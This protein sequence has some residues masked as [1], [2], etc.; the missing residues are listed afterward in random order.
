M[1]EYQIRKATVA[2]EDFVFENI[3]KPHLREPE[4]YEISFSSKLDVYPYLV[5][6]DGIPISVT[7][8][9]ILD[10][11]HVHQEFSIID[12]S[13][14]SIMGIPPGETVGLLRTGFTSPEYTGNGYGTA[15]LDAVTAVAT[16]NN[17]GYLVAEAWCHGG[18]DSPNN[19]L[20]TAGFEQKPVCK[21][22]VKNSEDCIKCG[23]DCSCEAVLYTKDIY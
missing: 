19:L 7:V 20:E 23:G 2:D 1:S 18:E 13:I 17:A 14:D 12:Q 21:N 10:A 5:E 16:I 11:Q 9:H 8:L 4:A 3:I 22:W 6:E 15:L